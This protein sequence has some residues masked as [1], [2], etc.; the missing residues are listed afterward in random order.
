MYRIAPDVSQIMS[1]QSSDEARGK[2]TGSKFC[3]EARPLK[4]G[5]E[6]EKEFTDQFMAL[7]PIES[8]KL[9]ES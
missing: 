4:S 9:I 1:V 8:Q 2:L 6:K 3:L 7:G 5:K